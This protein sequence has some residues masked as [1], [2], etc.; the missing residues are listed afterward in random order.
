MAFIDGGH[1]FIGLDAWCQKRL[2]VWWLGRFAIMVGILTFVLL[3]RQPGPAFGVVVPLGMSAYWH[4]AHAFGL[5]WSG[6]QRMQAIFERRRAL[7]ASPDYQLLSR[8]NGL[9]YTVTLALMLVGLGLPIAAGL[10]A[11]LYDTHDWRVMSLALLGF[12]MMGTL[13]L[14]LIY[15]V[16]RLQGM[17]RVREF[18]SYLEMQSPNMEGSRS[19]P[20][21]ILIYA[22]LT[23]AG[24]AAVATTTKMGF[25]IS[26]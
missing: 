7:G 25:A 10:S 21:Y 24:A 4:L 8:R 6:K 14:L 11:K 2:G 13:P 22:A 12:G 17:G 9:L 16:L 26:P 23:I 1:D 18:R 19:W 15:P 5:E 20:T 3:Y